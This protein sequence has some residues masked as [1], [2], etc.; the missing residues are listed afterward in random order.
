MIATNRINVPAMRS[1]VVLPTEC[2]QIFDQLANDPHFPMGTVFD[3][4]NVE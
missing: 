2:P 3:W 1:R 4:R